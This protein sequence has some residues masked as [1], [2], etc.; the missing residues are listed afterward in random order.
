MSILATQP[1]TNTTAAATQSAASSQTN[2]NTQAASQS[3]ST[4]SKLDMDAFMKLF[5]T[6]LQFQD[7]TNPMESYE[8]AAQLAQFTSVEKLNEVNSNL[9][10]V[11]GYLSSLGNAQMIGMVGKHV[12]G[13]SDTLKVT[14]GTS[15]NA[16]YTL[17]KT[18]KVTVRIYDQNDNL[19]RTIDAGTQTAGDYQ[20]NW[21]G[22]NDAKQTVSDGLYTV[23]LEAVDEQSN[24]LDIKTT[25]S[26]IVYSF[27]LEDGIAYLVLDGAGGIKLPV[28]N[29]MEVTA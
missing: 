10:N 13:Q 26:A 18:A 12:V 23:K 11:Q 2:S 6:Q 21:D 25:I 5:L 28:S 3:A 19:V 15:T 9:V 4:S 20:V 22:K 17:D 7:P 24:S 8:L 29:V 1:T 16:N 27:R 14:S